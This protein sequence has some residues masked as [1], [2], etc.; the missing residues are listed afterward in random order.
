MVASSERVENVHQ[1]TL[2]SAVR[3]S[4]SGI[5][6]LT[7]HTM[8]SL[9]ILTREGPEVCHGLTHNSSIW[10]TGTQTVEREISFSVVRVLS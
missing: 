2:Y 9:Q 5:L 4:K 6:F 10:P 8:H 7:V 3:T 1:I